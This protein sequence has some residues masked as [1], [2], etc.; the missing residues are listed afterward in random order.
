M[1]CSP[2][3]RSG[4]QRDALRQERRQRDDR[5]RAGDAEPEADEGK[6]GVAVEHDQPVQRRPQRQPGR[7]RRRSRVASSARRKTWVA[8]I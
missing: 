6:V 5:E 2:S 7:R 3:Q 8:K 1:E 4:A